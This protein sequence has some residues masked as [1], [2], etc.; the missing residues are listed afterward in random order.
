MKSASVVL[1][2][3][4][5]SVASGMD[6]PPILWARTYYPGEISGFYHVAVADDGGFA[7]AGVKKEGFGI[8]SDTCLFR[9][10]ANGD[11]LWAT[12]LGWDRQSA[13]WVEVLDDGGLVAVGAGKLLATS[14]YSL[15]LVRT[16]ADGQI[17]W[18][19]DYGFETSSECGNSVLQLPDGGFL[20]TGRVNGSGVYL[21]EAWV[22]RTDVYGDTLWTDIWGAH[23]VNYAQRALVV[24]DS[25][26]VLTYGR[27]HSDS[28]RG[29]HI[30][31]YSMDGVRTRETRITSVSDLWAADFCLA[32]DGGYVIT[33]EEMYA[34]VVHV[35][36]DGDLI[37][38]APYPLGDGTSIAPTMDGGYV[39]A[40]NIE[41]I[42][43]SP[44]TE[45]ISSLGDVDTEYY[46]RVVRY[47]QDGTMLWG[48]YVYNADCMYLYSIRQLSQ[49]GY[50]AAGSTTNG[51]GLLIRY[52]PETGIEEGVSPSS[53]LLLETPVPNPST[54]SFDI[55][56]QL[57][58]TMTVDLSV[59]D[60]SGRRVITLVSEAVPAG[61]HEAVW[62][63]G[64]A[65]SGCYLVVLRTE[66]ET[67]TQACV[68]MR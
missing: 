64:D 26:K 28:T 60:L 40:G 12:G 13:H 23:T 52:A 35:D 25:L 65:P 59:Y 57:P 10:D 15:F 31:T 42:P 36:W 54:G 20:V 51:T 66:D 58:A 14:S 62:D 39:Y 50:I 47:A 24:D 4:M 7:L 33:T 49:G 53:N 21:G 19:K 68:L 61:S 5:V 6:P 27:I 41:I 67:L 43:P 16:D 63:P 1:L 9:T 34:S 11:L 32:S 48:D 45:D 29:P 8:P 22:L 30:L 55:S 37:W 38:Q 17:L 56:L 18:V 2:I 46:G 3:L 44:G